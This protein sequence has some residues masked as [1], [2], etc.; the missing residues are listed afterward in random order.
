MWSGTDDF[1]ALDH[2][3][4]YFQQYR[5]LHLDSPGSHIKQQIP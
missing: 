2:L 4:F 5:W 3:Y 1:V